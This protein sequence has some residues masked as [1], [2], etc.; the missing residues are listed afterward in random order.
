MS[1]ERRPADTWQ[2]EIPGARWFK[3]DLHIHTIDDHPGGRAVL[4]AGLS[5]DEVDVSFTDPLLSVPGRPGRPLGTS[6]RLAAPATPAPPAPA[7][8]ALPAH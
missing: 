6:R 7:R 4:P 1:F 3:T 5:G 2:R 8:P